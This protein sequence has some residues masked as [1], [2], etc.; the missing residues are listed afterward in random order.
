MRVTFPNLA[1]ICYVLNPGDSGSPFSLFELYLSDS[2]P[3]Q[4]FQ[5]KPFCLE[6]QGV[7]PFFDPSPLEFQE[8]P[9][10]TLNPID[11]NLQFVEVYSMV[12]KWINV[13]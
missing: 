9:H 7:S 5:K 4:F 13:T 1:F 8:P 2:E 11:Y 3:C 10:L 6:F 12:E